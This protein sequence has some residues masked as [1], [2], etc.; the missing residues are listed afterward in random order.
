MLT[1]TYVETYGPVILARRAKSLRISTGNAKI[2]G[3]LATGRRDLK[4][5][6]TVVLARPILIMSE[7][8]VACTDLFLAL[9]YVV[10]FLYFE[11]YPIIFKGKYPLTEHFVKARHE[12]NVLI[13]VLS[14]V[15]TVSPM[16]MRLLRSYPVST[17]FEP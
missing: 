15:Y 8:I 2:Q 17:C 4:Q 16:D 11:A 7:P 6:V 14:Q 1:P 5:I 3:P 10:F 12:K 13:D 9:E